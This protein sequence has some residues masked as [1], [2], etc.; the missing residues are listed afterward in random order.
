[1]NTRSE[2]ILKKEEMFQSGTEFTSENSALL[3]TKQLSDTLYMNTPSLDSQKRKEESAKAITEALKK[4]GEYQVIFVAT[5]E[6][7]R[8]RPADVTMIKLVLESANE[9]THYGVIFNKLG[10]DIMAMMK[11]NKKKEFLAQVSLHSGPDQPLPIPLFLGVYEQL[12]DEENAT[13]TIPELKQFIAE[14]V[15]LKINS[16]TVKDISV[17]KYE[18]LNIQTQEQ[19]NN[20]TQNYK[21]MEKKV[22]EM[23]EFF[24]AKIESIID[25]MKV[26]HA[27]EK[28]ELEEHH[29]QIMKQMK[30][31][32]QQ[33]NE[34]EMKYQEDYTQQAAVQQKNH[35]DLVKHMDNLYRCSVM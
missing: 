10:K 21:E 28:K 19:I 23:E 14:L 9:I 27:N 22:R 31:Q 13:T 26:K 3:V 16:S 6:S 29:E 18:E 8:V 34:R 17:E 32:L 12:E 33:M 7:G 5:L 25:T 4:D 35:E 24:N 15:P 1:M 20:L 2:H 30:E 11:G